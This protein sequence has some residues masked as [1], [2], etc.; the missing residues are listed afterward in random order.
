MEVG[1]MIIAYPLTPTW[2]APWPSSPFLTGAGYD[3]GGFFEAPGEQASLN[4]IS[5]QR[6]NEGTVTIHF[7]GDP[8]APNYFCIMQG[9]RYMVRLYRPWAE[10]L[11]GT[12]E[13]PKAEAIRE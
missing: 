2:K 1:E 10:I 12:W 5:A 9:W 4:N 7:G 6:G 8:E 11:D 3:E 13:F